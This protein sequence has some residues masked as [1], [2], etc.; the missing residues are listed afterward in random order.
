MRFAAMVILSSRRALLTRRR[1][2]AKA[3]VPRRLTFAR[4]RASKPRSIHNR[5]KE[6]GAKKGRRRVARA[7][8]SRT[9][10]AV[11]RTG[12]K[13]YRVAEGDLIRIERL[14]G[15]AGETVTLGEVLILGDGG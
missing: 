2:A 1:H 7:I 9:M 15:E 5:A 6:T 12:G 14:P 8:R 10:Y 3:A 11:V 4:A 13:Q